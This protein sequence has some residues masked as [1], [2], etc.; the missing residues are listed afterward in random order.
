MRRFARYGLGVALLLALSALSAQ[1][2]RDP[3]VAPPDAG[4]SGSPTG[5]KTP[6]I[7]T[8]ALSILVRDGKA[9][10][11]VG[12]RLYAQGQALGSA[13]IE[14]ISETEVW[15]RE[16]G[17]LRR[18]PQFSGITRHAAMP[19]CAAS[20]AKADKKTRPSKTP[21]ATSTL[22]AVAPCAEEQP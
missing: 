10:L 1:T 5:E 8:G 4:L 17:A 15:L 22:P 18:L 12:T 16:D 3:T 6:A 20:A 11:L 9:F 21:R 14:R 13:R 7:A 2:L 19:A